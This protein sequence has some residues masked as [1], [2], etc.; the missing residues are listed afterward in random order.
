MMKGIDAFTEPFEHL[1][2]D[3]KWKSVVFGVFIGVFSV[4]LYGKV[5]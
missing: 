3:I 4:F 5:R 2:G 1:G